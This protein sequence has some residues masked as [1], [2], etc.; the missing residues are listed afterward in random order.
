MSAEA[1]LVGPAQPQVPYALVDL[2]KLFPEALLATALELEHIF[3][4]GG[5]DAMPNGAT[6]MRAH[7]Q[8][9]ASAT[10]VRIGVIS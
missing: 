1:T 9:R 3:M 7:S 5:G 10:S 8:K 4:L 2:V 6:A